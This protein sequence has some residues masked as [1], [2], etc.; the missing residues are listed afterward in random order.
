V[1]QITEVISTKRSAHHA[2][3]RWFCQNA[4]RP[5]AF[6]NNVIPSAPPR[7]R[8]LERYHAGVPEVAPD[9]V[10]YVN[11]LLEG[12]SDVLMNF[13]GKIPSSVERWNDKYLR[14]QLVR[15][16]NGK[17]VR[18]VFLRDPVNTL[19]SLAKRVRPK[20]SRSLF[21]FFY[22]VLALEQII[23]SLAQKKSSFCEKVVLMSPWLRDEKYRAEVAQYFQLT[24]G[25][26]PHEVTRQGGGSSFNGMAYDPGAN[27]A[28]LNERW[29]AVTDNPLFLSAFA[30][31][32][33]AEAVRSYFRMYG[34]QEAFDAA[35]IDSF[36]ARAIKEPQAQDYLKRML[37]PLRQARA[38]LDAM[39]FAPQPAIRELWKGVLTTRMM[40]RI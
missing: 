15:P 28:A 2:F 30:D 16:M 38:T 22:Q 12:D 5:I 14:P 39:E 25:P 17:L 36:E 23:T 13:E 21:K 8:E 37:A 26:P 24:P 11:E 34:A 32:Q 27:A 31:A 33:T 20:Q 9:S 4:G 18:V 1:R 40:L 7:L 29:K 10:D 3:I 35:T 6:F 19:A